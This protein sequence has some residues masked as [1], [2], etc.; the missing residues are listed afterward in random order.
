MGDPEHKL[1]CPVFAPPRPGVR[2]PFRPIYALAVRVAL[3]LPKH[4]TSRLILANIVVVRGITGETPDASAPNVWQF[5]RYTSR[6]ARY[7]ATRLNYR[8]AV[9]FISH[10]VLT[11]RSLAAHIFH[12]RRVFVSTR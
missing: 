11:P 4:A 1:N 5:V 2:E 3:R 7:A 10:D 9:V 12:V 6:M 8:I